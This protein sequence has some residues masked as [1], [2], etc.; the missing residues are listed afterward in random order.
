[1]SL[2]I[3]IADAVVSELNTAAGGGGFS[4]T[5]TAQRQY[6]PIFDL[7][8]LKDRHV[9]VVPRGAAIQSSGRDRNQH[10]VQIDV[11]VQKKQVP[12]PPGEVG[13]PETNAQFDPLMKLV[14][15]IADFFRLRRLASPANTIWIK[16]EH[17]TLYS[18]EHVE[19]HRQFTSVITLTFRVIR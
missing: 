5:F 17:S 9:T 11:A 6:V 4:Q 16:T 10:D 13:T 12:G 19:Q 3:D 1:V 15:E 14:E 2:I 8:E 7:A 18:P